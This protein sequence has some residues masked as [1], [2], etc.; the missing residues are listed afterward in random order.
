M[1]STRFAGWIIS[2]LS[3]KADSAN[4]LCRKDD[5]MEK[6]KSALSNKKKRIL[7]A[8][9]AVVAIAFGVTSIAGILWYREHRM[10]WERIEKAPTLEDILHVE[11]SSLGDGIVVASSERAFWSYRNYIPNYY[12][13]FFDSTGWRKDLG[14]SR[15]IW[16]YETVK[17][18]IYDLRTGERIETIDVLELLDTFPQEMEGYQLR[19]WVSIRKDNEGALSINW[20]VVNIPTSPHT[21]E[22]LKTLSLDLNE[23]KVTLN[24]V[25]DTGSNY[26]YRTQEQ[27]ELIRQLAI[28]RGWDADESEEHRF[29]NNNGIT[30]IDDRRTR[31][32]SGGL[33][34]QVEIT[35]T[36]SHLPHESYELYSRFPGLK[37]FIGRGNIE[38]VI[39]ID[40]Y[41]TA[42]EILALLM[43]DGREISFEGCV[44]C[45]TRSVDGQE[46]EINSFEDFFR[47]I[48]VD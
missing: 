27:S 33:S 23:R 48:D 6:E 28:F 37:E 31:V 5:T 21:P 26:I 25:E 2:N 15:I 4:I 32:W 3:G 38:V 46:H 18:H 39:I 24:R 42:K 9:V 11:V 1:E 7:M 47:W 36:G 41:P 44:L 17:T 8:I 30:L 12:M 16:R 29:L 19:G 20:P 34:G 22:M 43:E 40:N 13:A 10:G 35:M 14:S 45:Y